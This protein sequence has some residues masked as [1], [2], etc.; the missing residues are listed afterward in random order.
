MEQ[1][2]ELFDPLRFREEKGNFNIVPL[3]KPTASP[4]STGQNNP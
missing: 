1:Q 4:T 2:N 3:D